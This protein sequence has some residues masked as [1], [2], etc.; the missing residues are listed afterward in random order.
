MRL[1]LRLP[2]PRVIPHDQFDELLDEGDRRSGP[3][4]YRPSCPDCRA[5]EAIRVPV[6]RFQPTRS[7]RRVLRRNDGALRLELTAPTVTATHLSLYNR[8][9]SERG[10]S[11]R[12]EAATE[13]DYRFFLVE[14]CVDTRELRYYLG[15]E[16]IAVSILDFGQTAVSSVYHYFNP[17]H[18]DRSLGVYS[19]LQEIALCA[20]L[21]LEWYYLGL[22]VA[23]CRH[24]RYKADYYPHQRRVDGVWRE[25]AGPDDAVGT[26]VEGA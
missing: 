25:F 12:T 15:D 20:R 22:Y 16:L 1:P 17:D 5:C 24:L 14:S 2:S 26:V 6:A 11:R 4:L 7:Q 8:H 18:A 21:G 23:D 10:L 13:R 3:L 19:I 9:K